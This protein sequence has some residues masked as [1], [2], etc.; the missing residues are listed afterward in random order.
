MSQNA[1]LTL[2][3]NTLISTI[4]S[5]TYCATLA[6]PSSV[7]TTAA[8]DISDLKLKSDKDESFNGVSTISRIDYDLLGLSPEDVDIAKTYPLNYD[9][10]E[11][12][13]VLVMLLFDVVT[14][15]EM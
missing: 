6:F 9:V 11:F 10:I 7:E 12:E 14:V 3:I 1:H 8:T 15:G 4:T 5:S 13:S 2:T